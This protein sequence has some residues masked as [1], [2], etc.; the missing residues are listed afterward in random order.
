[1]TEI[2]DAFNEEEINNEGMGHNND[3][4]YDPINDRYKVTGV[5]EEEFDNDPTGVQNEQGDNTDV[6]LGSERRR[7]IKNP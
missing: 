7:N 6:E 2:D 4:N 1:M 5:N 3:D